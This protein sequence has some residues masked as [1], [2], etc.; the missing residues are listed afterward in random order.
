MPISIT[1]VIIRV[2]EKFSVTADR[3]SHRHLLYKLSSIGVGGLFL[4]LSRV[5][6]DQS[7]S[8]SANSETEIL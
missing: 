4:S 8:V 7:L 5:H 3:L 1:S 2:S 6:T